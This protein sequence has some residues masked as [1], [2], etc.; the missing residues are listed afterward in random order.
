MAIGGQIGGCVPLNVF[1]A[2]DKLSEA[3]ATSI[4]E[5][6]NEAIRS[7]GVFSMALSG[8]SLPKVTPQDALDP[9]CLLLPF[10]PAASVF[11]HSRVC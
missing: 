3:C 4:F 2:N 10:W 5:L 1:E 8:G 11:P 6:A 7:R 9:R